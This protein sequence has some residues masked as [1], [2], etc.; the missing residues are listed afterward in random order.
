MIKAIL[1]S[2]PL[3]LVGLA[4]V[5]VTSEQSPGPSVVGT[6]SD[7]S[8]HEQSG[9]L[10]GTEIRLVPGRGK[11]FAVVQFADGSPGV[12]MIAEV[13]ID[14]VRVSFSV[15]SSSG[16]SDAFVGEVGKSG[17]HGTFTFDGGATEA[18]TLPRGCGYWDRSR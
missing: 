4:G 7:F 12:P 13:K 2:V 14:G 3:V 15:P 17:L 11:V 5:S 10:N 8:F 18:L 9:D 6:Y 16:G 1:V